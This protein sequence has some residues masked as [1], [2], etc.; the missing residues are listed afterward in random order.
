LPEPTNFIQPVLK[1][2]GDTQGAPGLVMP[3]YASSLSDGEIARLGAYL[4]STRKIS[5]VDGPRK[6]GRCYSQ[7][8]GEITMT[9]MDSK[10]AKRS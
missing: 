9:D 5:A 8:F 3:A 2:V 6:Q 10:G 7:G 1:D 4:R